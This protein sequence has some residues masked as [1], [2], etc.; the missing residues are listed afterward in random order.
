MT[1]PLEARLISQALETF[2]GARV[3]LYGQ[4]SLSPECSLTCWSEDLWLP[5]LSGSWLVL[6]LSPA[7]EPQGRLLPMLWWPQGAWKTR[8]VR[9][10][11]LR[12]SRLKPKQAS[13][14]RFLAAACSWG[15]ISHLPRGQMLGSPQTVPATGCCWLPHSSLS[16]Q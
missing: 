9:R 5:F 15:G 1:P 14:R 6:P 2:Q 12:G 7:S 3:S 11:T 8:G 4:T 13:R 10:E 16:S